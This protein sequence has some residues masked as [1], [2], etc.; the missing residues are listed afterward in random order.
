[1]APEKAAPY[2]ET[3]R[4]IQRTT[5]RKIS[6]LSYAMRGDYTLEPLAY[7]FNHR[8]LGLVELVE[9]PLAK[10]VGKDISHRKDFINMWPGSRVQL[11][12]PQAVQQDSH[13]L[14]IRKTIRQT[15]FVYIYLLYRLCQHQDQ[16]R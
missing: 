2:I 8:G 13:T 1:M 7:G 5:I 11:M 6:F 16:S 9:A 12:D 4:S 3:K 10:Y 15:N 14:G